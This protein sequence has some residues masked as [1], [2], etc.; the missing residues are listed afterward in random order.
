M[1]DLGIAT[2]LLGLEEKWL[3]P[4]EVQDPFNHDADLRGYLSLKP[5]S[6][7][8]ALAITCVNGRPA[9][10]RIFA[11]P[12]LHYP[13][14]RMGAFHFPPV[15]SVAI[16]EKLDGTNVL[17]Y[18]YCDAEGNLHTTYKLRLF[19]VLRNGKWGA[20]LDMWREMLNRYPSIGELPAKNDCAVSFELYGA[21]NVHLV[22]YERPLD[23]AVLFGVSG[24]GGLIPPS[25]LETGGVSMPRLYGELRA[26]EDPVAAY[27]RIREEVERD[28][29]KL[30]DGK[31]KGSEGAVWYVTS[32]SGETVIFKCKPDSVEEV[33][34]T[35]GINKTA[36]TM[37]CWNL[38]ETSDILSYETLL[39]LLLED[40][41]QEEIDG[42]RAHI[43]ACIE[44]VNRDLEF[45]RRVLEAYARTGLSIAQDKGAVMRALSGKFNRGEM[46]KVYALI[47]QQ[48]AKAS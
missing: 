21:Q 47:A 38:L 9:P 28:I 39:P 33:H 12:K 3:Q 45:Q 36:V 35:R 2:E 44:E 29:E 26:G 14:D 1:S 43:D 30:E 4:F 37:T 16:Y 27:A 32:A 10:Q 20:F 22:V 31:L 40:Y 18:R 6:R 46:K 19:P 34:W 48:E 7:Y 8:G 11:T 17:A 15:K 13:F 42:F 41:T 23:C 5:D 24:S 25:S